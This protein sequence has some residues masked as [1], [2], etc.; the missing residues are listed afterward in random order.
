MNCPSPCFAP[1]ID[2]QPKPKYIYIYIYVCVC[3][4]VTSVPLKMKSDL[5]VHLLSEGGDMD[6]AM[7]SRREAV[8]LQPALT[9]VCT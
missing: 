5:T 7:S 8:M 1:N 3:V 2:T 6:F 4:C 9:V